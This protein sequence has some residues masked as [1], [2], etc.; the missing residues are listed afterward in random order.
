MAIT[1]DEY[2]E[3]ILGL[4]DTIK[5]DIITPNSSGSEIET[6]YIASEGRDDEQWLGYLRNS[7]SV[8]DIWL[9][10]ISGLQGLGEDDDR[11]GATGTFTKPVRVVIDY[12][13]DYR[14]GVD[15]IEDADPDVARTNTE[16]EFLKKVLAVDLALEKKRGCLDSR[17]YIDKWDMILKLRRFET[18]TTHWMSGV[19]EIGF[20]DIIL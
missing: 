16:T 13:S 2:I 11:K 14:H 17:I 3:L 7:A 6:R 1:K 8:V 10:T 9:L 20:T 4:L 19:L 12:Y 5:T 15:V 18:A